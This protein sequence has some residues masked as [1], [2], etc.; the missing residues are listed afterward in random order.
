MLTFAT[1]VETFSP[2]IIKH[3]LDT[4]A[5]VNRTIRINQPSIHIWSVVPFLLIHIHR[6]FP[7]I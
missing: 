6:G 5:V 1:V 7:D 2:Q 3:L 4:C